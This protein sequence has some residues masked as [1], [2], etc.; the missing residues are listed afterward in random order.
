M[1]LESLVSQNDDDDY[2]II[3]VDNNS[4]DG[5]HDV[6]ESFSEDNDL[7]RVA[8][9]KE[10][11]SSYAAR[12]RGIEIARG[13]ILCFIDADMTVEDGYIEKVRESVSKSESMYFGL[14]VE[15]YLPEETIVGKYNRA[16]GFP[17]AE[18]IKERNFVP[19]CCLVVRRELID[20]VGDF[21]ERMISSGDVEFGQRVA[22]AGYGQ[23]YL[24][25]VVVYHP[26]RTTLRSMMKKKYRIGRGQVQR[27]HRHPGFFDL[28]HPLHPRRFLPQ[29]PLLLR[30]RMSEEPFLRFLL[31]Y[32][33]E[34]VLRLANTAGTL[35]EWYNLKRR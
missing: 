9:E 22:R 5:T 23:E 16:Y 19:T 7:I 30:K 27:A 11:Q 20:A 29:R 14:N 4:T 18:F 24:S 35:S 8:V 31:Y 34:Y 1:T 12:N 28:Q 17:V 15:I 13:S 10:F 32:V 2:E 25:K 33:I 21:D 3:V 26:A 6:A